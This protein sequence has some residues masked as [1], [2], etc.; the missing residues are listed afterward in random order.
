MKNLM[1]RLMCALS[2]KKAEGIASVDSLAPGE[3]LFYF[4]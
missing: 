1:H 3:C 4:C 2:G